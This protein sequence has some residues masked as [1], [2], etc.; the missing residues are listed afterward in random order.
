[1]WGLR[2]DFIDLCFVFYFIYFVLMILICWWFINIGCVVTVTVF[3]F[4]VV[5]IF[6]YIVSCCLHYKELYILFVYD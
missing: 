6:G 2:V 4:S 3:Y 1:M 5:T